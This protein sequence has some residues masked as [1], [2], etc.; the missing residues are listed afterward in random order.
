MRV[1]LLLAL[2]VAVAIIMVALCSRSTER[3]PLSERDAFL[4]KQVLV[5]TFTPQRAEAAHVPFSFVA[6]K[7]VG[8]MWALSR[9]SGISAY[10]D[11]AIFRSG[12]EL[13]RVGSNCF[14][15]PPTPL[16]PW[17]P[18]L[19]VVPQIRVASQL[20][21]VNSDGAAYVV[22]DA[23]SGTMTVHEDLSRLSAGSITTTVSSTSPFA[24]SG[25]FVI[26]AGS[27]SERAA[28]A[29]LMASTSHAAIPFVMRQRL[30]YADH[31]SLPADPIRGYAFAGCHAA[32][33]LERVL[34]FSYQA[35]FNVV[36]PNFIIDDTTSA[37]PAL[38][39]VIPVPLGFTSSIES[40]LN[41]ARTT[42]PQVLPL[43]AGVVFCAPGGSPPLSVY[44]IL[45]VN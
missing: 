34:G 12:Q 29:E 7:G 11:V 1:H 6:V 8:W 4:A 5:A 16:T 13:I 10:P 2:C 32:P 31:D 20:S 18:G 37:G 27:A 38:E 17:I 26:R 25:T 41:D 19:T 3:N 14:A 30:V 39:S 21:V 22:G 28:A 45:T 44:E 24:S 15:V 23:S 42:A 33:V 40:T 43:K 35:P 36:Q 9:A